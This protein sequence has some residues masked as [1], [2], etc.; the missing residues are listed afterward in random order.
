MQTGR[1]AEA[2]AGLRDL[3][4][5]GGV[6]PQPER[7]LLERFVAARDERAFAALVRRHGPMVA[8]ACRAVL[9]D[10]ADADDAFQAT[11]LVLARRAGTLRDP[12]RLGPWLHGVARRVSL[13]ARADATRRLGREAP[14][15]DLVALA[16]ARPA[17]SAEAREAAALIHA[18]LD[19]LS[20]PERSAVVLCDL[21]GLSHQEAADQLGWPLSTVKTR[22]TRGRDRLRARLA[23]RGVTLSATALAAA[24]AGEAVA[25][26]VAPPL[27]L[28]TAR[29]AVALGAGST[30]AVGLASPALV[31]T[32]G[33]AR[34]MILGKLKA[35]TL[36]LAATTA[37]VAAP[38]VV[39]RPPQAPP[40]TPATTVAGTDVDGDGEPDLFVATQ[41]PA[42]AA[43]AT[44]PE[45]ATI[46]AP[47]AP[48]DAATTTVARTPITPAREAGPAFADDAP[49]FPTSHVPRA[50]VADQPDAAQ[51]V[52]ASSL[53]SGHAVIVEQAPVA[54]PSGHEIIHM[55]PPLPTPTT[56]Q[57]APGRR[58]R[59]EPMVPPDARPAMSA[60]A[61][62]EATIA[63][64]TLATLRRLEQP[65]VVPDILDEFDNPDHPTLFGL[66]RIITRKTAEEDN[67]GPPDGLRFQ[68]SPEARDVA[69]RHGIEVDR[70]QPVD[71]GEPG[72]FN[73]RVALTR[74]AGRANLYYWVA[75]GMIRFDVFPDTR[76]AA[77]ATAGEIDVFPDTRRANP[78]PAGGI[79][80][81]NPSPSMVVAPP[82][83]S[84]AHPA[85]APTAG[86]G[87]APVDPVTVA[88]GDAVTPPGYV[89]PPDPG[90]ARADEPQA[91]SAT[92][93][94][95][96]RASDAAPARPDEAPPAPPRR[97]RIDGPAPARSHRAPT[98]VSR[99]ARAEAIEEGVPAAGSP[100]QGVRLPD[101]GR[102][103]PAQAPGRPDEG[104][105]PHSPD[106][107]TQPSAPVVL[108]EGMIESE[109]MQQS[110]TQRRR[111][112]DQERNE[113]I[114]A[115]LDKEVSFHFP[116]KVTLDK[117]L[118][119]V[120]I[121]TMGPDRKAVPI[122][123]DPTCFGP[124]T[125]LPDRT[126]VA[127]AIDLDDVPLRVGLRLALR[128]VGLEFV[129]ADGLIIIGRQ[130]TMGEF[131]APGGMGAGMG[132][133][134]KGMG[135]MM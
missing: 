90:P 87:D 132:G 43:P 1:R 130:G 119:L 74:E 47:A 59:R 58:P 8:G 20:P 11:F 40:A 116:E 61:A 72:R 42:A 45:A 129:V 48:A 78:A 114:R 76:R 35:L 9:A 41:A 5:A 92:R 53:A 126:Q 89:T 68:F 128:Q 98:A 107:G 24:L 121:E 64:L 62:D 69:R 133:G 131:A 104:V 100:A 27:I 70:W 77:S 17:R 44:L 103:E 93:S 7:D 125:S 91:Q 14:N 85:P 31:T 16:P 120:K 57:L 38:G 109:P 39:A 83:P 18:E 84:H 54:L 135:G 97:D 115:R 51:A 15:P 99:P 124:G 36:G 106:R 134:M 52:P 30:L 118:E 19:R 88:T 13:R 3:F 80:L 60:N 46:A 108:G 10:P 50:R 101:Q 95:S 2:G 23:R 96:A 33:A 66:C 105:K 65:L 123:V 12:D 75:D 127:I 122:Y 110:P 94:R 63:R 55:R 25:A 67:D 4:E 6:L 102:S 111:L 79:V 28:A 56:S 34:A 117:V 112:Q 22:I 81:A 82:G 71:P 37:T 21:E 113:A 26:S 86:L 32:P 49:T 29:A 73:L